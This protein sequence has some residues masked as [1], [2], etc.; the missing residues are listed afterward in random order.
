MDWYATKIVANYPVE[1]IHQRSIHKGGGGKEGKKAIH[2]HRKFGFWNQRR[3]DT[4][5]L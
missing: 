5:D 1:L 4:V 2:A 3:V